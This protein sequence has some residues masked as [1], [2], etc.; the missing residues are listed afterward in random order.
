MP[1]LQCGHSKGDVV[2][3]D[4]APGAVVVAGPI[5]QYVTD[6]AEGLL[7]LQQRRA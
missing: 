4:A 5:V 1:F 6:I 2:A 3:E 7:D